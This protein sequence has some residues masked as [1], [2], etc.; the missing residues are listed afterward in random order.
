[1]YSSYAFRSSLG[2]I[3]RSRFI[4]SP[5]GGSSWDPVRQQQPSAPWKDH[6]ALVLALQHVSAIGVALWLPSAAAGT[7]TATPLHQVVLFHQSEL[8]KKPFIA[9]V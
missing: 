2:Y 5:W 8:K 1:M 3:T 9:G 4:Y 6:T 7:A